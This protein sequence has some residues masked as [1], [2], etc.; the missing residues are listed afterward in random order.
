M[1]QTDRTE[2]DHDHRRPDEPH[3]DAD[4]D[5]AAR[6]CPAR[7]SPRRPARPR[8]HRPRPAWQPPPADSGRNASLIL[9]LIILV[10]GGWFFATR[11]LGL[12]LPRLDWGQAWPILLIGLGLWVVWRSMQRSR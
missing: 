1:P 6:H 4:A 3:A 8:R 11:T 9:G 10:I 7:H 2:A 5:P 12:D